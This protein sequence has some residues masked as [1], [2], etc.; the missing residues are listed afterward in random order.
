[1]WI[2]WHKCQSLIRHGAS[3]PVRPTPDACVSPAGNQAGRNQQRGNGRNRT[4]KCLCHLDRDAD[5]MDI[6]CSLWKNIFFQCCEKCIS[7]STMWSK[8]TSQWIVNE[9]WSNTVNVGL[10]CRAL[11]H[12]LLSA[13]Q[14]SVL[15][16]LHKSKMCLNVMHAEK[17]RA[18]C[19]PNVDSVGSGTEWHLI[20]DLVEFIGTC[21]HLTV[22]VTCR[23]FTW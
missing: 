18:V 23:L 8:F 22:I 17:T 3:L 12:I 2:D 9:R 7:Q 5:W 10:Y 1:M 11:T 15:L 16:C 20:R 6:K 19:R 14:T 13:V 21:T 4:D